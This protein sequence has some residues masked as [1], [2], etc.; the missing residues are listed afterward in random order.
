MSSFATF[1]LFGSEWVIPPPAYWL[2][3]DARSFEAFL[4]AFAIAYATN[5]ILGRRANRQIAELW[6][7]Q[8][9]GGVRARGQGAGSPRGRWGKGSGNGA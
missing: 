3:W 4:F 9:R 1:T 6:A 7:S 5:I 8:V 2:P